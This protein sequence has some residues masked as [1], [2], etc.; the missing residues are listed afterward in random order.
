MPPPN[1]KLG[2]MKRFNRAVVVAAIAAAAMG[3]TA[4][5][6]AEAQKT[7]AQ[8]DRVF[9]LLIGDKPAPDTLALP[10][11]GRMPAAAKKPDSVK[12]TSP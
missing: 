9:R 3:C 11:L 7:E 5:K 1:R 8:K 6:K 2:N 12:V 4:Q 10:D